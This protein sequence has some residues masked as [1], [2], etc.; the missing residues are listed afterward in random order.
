MSDADDAADDAPDVGSLS[1]ETARLFGAISGWARE[2]AGDAG[3]SIGD[4]GAHAAQ[5]AHEVGEHVATG[6]AECTWC[7]VCRGI[8]WVRDLSPEVRTHLTVA[9]S[10]LAHAASALLAAPDTDEE[11]GSGVESID[12]DDDWPEGG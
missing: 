8:A 9:A 7:P 10:S 2:Q 1:E 12:L 6:S 11:P 4:L 3:H 5:A